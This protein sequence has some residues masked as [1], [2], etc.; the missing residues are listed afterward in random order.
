MVVFAMAQSVSYKQSRRIMD[1]HTRKVIAT[2][3]LAALGSAFGA[4]AQDIFALDFRS[5]VQLFQTTVSDFVG[6]LTAVGPGGLP[7]SFAIDT[8]AAGDTL[9]AVEFAAGHPTHTFD[10]NDGT[11]TPLGNITG[12]EVDANISGM[13]VDP[14][15]GDWYIVALESTGAN[16]YV[17]DITTGVFNLVGNITDTFI[18]DIAID[19]EGNAFGHNISDDLLY[20]IDLTTGFG[21]PIGSTGQAANFAQGMDFDPATDTLYATVYTGGGTGV[22]GR[23]NLGTGNLEVIQDT[24]PTNGEFEMVVLPPAQKTDVFC[25]SE[26]NINRGLVVDGEFGNT[27]GSDDVSWQWRPDALAATVVA[28][29]NIGFGGVTTELDPSEYAFNIETRASDPGVVM[30]I[31]IFNFETNAFEGAV[32]P[33]IPTTD[34]SFAV[35]RD[36]NAGDY[37]GPNGGVRARVSWFRPAGVPPLWN[38]FIDDLTWEITP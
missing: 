22:F 5:G 18:I 16:L 3:T 19:S 14:T 35:I 11:S 24:T 21:V 1:M 26:F 17:G 38:I 31:E 25:A 6:D 30:R 2:A 8:N 32:F 37:V 27:C 13:A 7:T 29:I 36:T 28:P 9:Y 4:S 10:M 20:E 12:P 34:T 23:F 33:D 15:T